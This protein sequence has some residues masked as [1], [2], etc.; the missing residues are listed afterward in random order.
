MVKIGLSSGWLYAQNKTDLSSQELFFKEVDGVEL[1]VTHENRFDTYTKEISHSD[2]LS[3]HISGNEQHFEKIINLY[4]IHYPENVV[5]HP[6]TATEQLISKYVNKNIPISIENT[7]KD[8]D[9]GYKINELEFIL[10]KYNINLTVDVQHI[11]ERDRTMEYGYE[12]LNNF[13]DDIVELHVSGQSER[14]RHEL[15]HKSDNKREICEFISKFY[16]KSS[17][18]MIIE[19]KYEN[20]DDLNKEY[21]LLKNLV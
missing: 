10:N 1:S 20:I 5:I 4:S 16:N 9:S 17:A 14:T 2:Y 7:D 8:S 6:D 18:P 13:E 12:L 3:F 19:G 21:N 11:Y 15:I